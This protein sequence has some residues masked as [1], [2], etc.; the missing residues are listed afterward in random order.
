MIA[1]ILTS[2]LHTMK[3][4]YANQWFG[5]VSMQGF[6]QMIESENRYYGF[7]Y[8]KKNKRESVGNLMFSI[9][10]DLK[11]KDLR[12]FVG[13]EVPGM[14]KYYSNIIVAGEGTNLT[15]I[16]NESSVPIE[17]VTKEREIAKDKVT[18]AEKNNPVQKRT[19][20]KSESAVYIYH[21]HSWESFF[22]LLPGATDP[23]SP[24]VN[25]SLLGKRMKEQLEGQGIPVVHDKTNMGDLLASKKWV[26]Y[27]SYK[28][29][30]EY[31]KEALA[32][33]NKIAFPIDIH[34][35]DQRK[36]VTTKVI[37]GKSYA[38][39]YF[40]IG[41]EN[42]GRAENE[43][44]ARAI[45]SYLDENYYGLSRG[46]FPKYKKMEMAFITKIYRKMRC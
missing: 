5:K 22:P 16:P 26:W 35:D 17:E 42:E 32:Q 3:S 28:A 10:T 8:F 31:V 19:E 39:L 14:S 25:V 45:N 6:V 38:R 43:K 37:N 7:D 2:F 11:I 29:S 46:I 1:S 15:N 33:N 41:M 20:R 12:T 40:I 24:D 4:N 18:E 21:T 27:Q 34:R 23:S 44:I 13:K 30:H 36:K 9:A